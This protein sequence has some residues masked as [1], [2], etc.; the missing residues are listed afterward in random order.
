MK[1]KNLLAA[2]ILT[3]FFSGCV[4][5]S[6]YPIYTEKDL[7]PNDILTGVWTDGEGAI[8]TFEHPYIGE[9]IPENLD[10]KR[11]QLNAI[12]EEGKESE[13]AVH[14]IKLGEHL[15]A[16]F[17]LEDFDGFDELGLAMFHI[18][19]IHTFAKL[20]VVED[21]IQ[22]NWFDPEWLKEMID[23]N[24]IRIHHEDNGEYVLLTANPKE[25]Q[26][27]VSK[28]VEEEAAFEDGVDVGLI[29]KK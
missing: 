24:K 15:I 11:Y 13:Y 17:F 26:K 22:F 19:P 2:L 6:F 23:K 14:I 12:D 1:A 4:V 29:R 20:T 8:W 16:D 10:T 3:V 5:F 7:F 28:Y 21:T 25:L 18:V 9:Q 27:F